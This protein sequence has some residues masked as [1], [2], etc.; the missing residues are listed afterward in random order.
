MKEIVKVIAE[1]LVDKPE[2]VSV[3][4]VKG[5]N[6]TIIKLN[7]AP[8]DIGKIIGK[9]GRTVDAIRTLVTAVSAKSNTRTVLEV[10]E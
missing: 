5:A 3:T 8:T 9:Q 7:V 10:V 2:A 4:E 6:T 1:A